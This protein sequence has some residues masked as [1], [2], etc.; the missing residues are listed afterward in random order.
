MKPFGSTGKGEVCDSGESSHFML[1]KSV[2]GKL[3]NKKTEEVYNTIKKEFG[4][5]PFSPKHLEYYISDPSTSVKLLSL[6]KF[7]DPYPPLVDVPGSL[8]AQY[9]HTVYLSEGSKTIMTLGDDY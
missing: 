8:I 3:Y 6:R 7:I 9:E 4:T 5:L 1:S 2:P